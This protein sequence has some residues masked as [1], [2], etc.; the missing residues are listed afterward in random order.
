V[1][2]APLRHEAVA[3]VGSG[4]GEGTADRPTA[5]RAVVGNAAGTTGAVAPGTSA[6]AHV[7]S[8]PGPVKRA[9]AAGKSAP[10]RRARP[11]ERLVAWLASSLS[12]FFQ[13]VP[14]RPL[15]RLAAV[16]GVLLYFS[17]RRRRRLVRGNLRLICCWLVANGRATPVVARAARSPVALERL[18]MGAFGH[19]LRYYIEVA[20][21][22]SYDAA[23]LAER[24]V[25]ESR[26]VVDDAL[27]ARERT[28]EGRIFVGL[29][30]G[31][32]E[33]PG[34][35]AVHNAGV[36]ITAPMEAIPNAPL[37]EYLVERRGAIGVRL[38]PVEGARHALLRALARG[39]IAGLV[40]DRDLTGDGHPVTL[41]GEPTRLPAGPG[42]LALS[43]GAPTYVAAA[44]RTGLGEYA[45]RGIRLETPQQGTLRER[46]GIFMDAEARA[47]EELVSD[48]PEQWWT[49]FFPIWPAGFARAVAS[50]ELPA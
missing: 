47:I 1:S 36:P 43:S 49:I 32:I 12:W 14:D 44:R 40:A 2:T 27:G 22:P 42:L 23:Y 45:L 50:G 8:A 41:F 48:A 46:L 7:P 15:H 20:L 5:G 11:A 17:W 29:H 16:A 24:L 9:A 25:I 4:A 3:E 19:Y 35:Y 26:D 37:Q 10:V 6:P 13:R 39:E 18:V 38:I 21:A 33:L 30:L 28:G 34:L 31:G